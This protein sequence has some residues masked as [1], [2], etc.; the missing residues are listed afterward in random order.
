MNL[1]SLVLLVPVVFAL[2]CDLRTREIP[3]WIP[4]LIV[5]WACLATAIGLHRVT[6]IGL[7]AGALLGLGLSAAVFYLGG[8][9]GGDVKLLA[10]IGAAV[11]PWAL[12]SIL[13]W[14]A[15][16]GGLLALIAAA[17]GKRDFAY[18]PAIAVG[19]RW[20]RFG[21]EDSHMCCCINRSTAVGWDQR[22]GTICGM[23]HGRRPTIAAISLAHGRP[24]LADPLRGCPGLFP[25]CKGAA[26]VAGRR[27]SNLPSSP[28]WS[29]SCWAAILTFGQLFYSGQTVQQA[30]DVAAREISRTPLLATAKLMDVL[31]SN[32]PS[33]YSTAAAAAPSA[34]RCSIRSSCSST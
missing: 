34:R 3:D 33:D 20:K 6:W 12:L 31:Y 22:A 28:W 29:I 11:G 1:W 4:L 15:F 13:A 25:P 5:A 30:A 2:V 32:N 7:M 23:D 18:V 26:H 9:G 16:A 14:M 27:W 17:R 19:V 10:A 21:R 24:V 8:L